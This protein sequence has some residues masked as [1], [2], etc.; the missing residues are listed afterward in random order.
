MN[1][2]VTSD[3]HF[4]HNNIIKYCNRPFDSVNHMNDELV[5]RWNDTVKPQD[6]VFHL[7]DIS[8][9]DVE[10][11]NEIMHK[12]KGNKILIQGNHDRHAK[13]TS[14]DPKLM[15]NHFSEIHDFLRLRHN[16]KKYV[17]C[18]FP[19]ASWDRGY[20][21]LHGHTHGKYNDLYAQLDVGVDSH[22]YYPRPI[23]LLY[24]LALINKKK[25]EYK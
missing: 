17:L 21:N 25:S 8:F 7:G 11:T 12:L 3:T 2:Y 10:Q 19:F 6:T 15:Y 4:F 20:I 1:I 16:N 24:N 13:W 5:Y 14:K 22:E 18:H 23:E 9:G